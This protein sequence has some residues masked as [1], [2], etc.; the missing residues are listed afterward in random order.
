MIAAPVPRFE[1]DG[2]DYVGVLVAQGGGPTRM[3]ALTR[4]LA[5]AAFLLPEPHFILEPHLDG[6]SR[7]DICQRPL[8]PSSKF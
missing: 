7:G 6:L 5:D 2:S 1:Q 4:A 3:G 8:D